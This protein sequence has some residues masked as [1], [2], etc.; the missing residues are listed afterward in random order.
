MPLVF[1][2]AT[3]GIP[4]GALLA[5][6]RHSRCATACGNERQEKRVGTYRDQ[7]VINSIGMT[8]VHIPA[9]VFLM[10]APDTDDLAQKDEKPQHKVRISQSFYL[11]A[12]EITVAQFRTFVRETGFKT[13]A[14]TDGKGASGY[15]AEWRGFEYNSAKYFWQNPGYQQDE[16]HPV[17]NVNWHDA[18]AFCAWLSKKE[19][20][21]YR[22]PTEAEWEYACRAGTT[23]RFTTGNAPED[24]KSVANLCDQALATKWD[25]STVQK[26]GLDPKIIKFQSW[27]DGHAFTAPVGSFKPNA[28]G[29]N[30][31]L[32]NVGE[33][34]SDWYQSDYYRESPELNPK[35]PLKDKMGHVVRGGTFLNGPTL[36]RATSRVECEDLY[37][38]YV[39]GFRVLL[40]VEGVR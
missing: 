16:N 20:R 34:C 15:N 2:V 30:D 14:E 25:T 21:K 11:A 23:T 13:A 7:K 29:L 31:M 18:E 5:C 3:L 28:F 35:G 39:I 37:R 19:H 32:G 8:F 26:H 36:V 22:L 1:A 4:Y 40:E 12:H 10:G 33:F 38:N 24:L 9:G 6:N 17:V 27:N